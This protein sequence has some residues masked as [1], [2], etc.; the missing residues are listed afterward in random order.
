MATISG[1]TAGTTP[2]SGAEVL[3]A[4]VSLGGTTERFTTADVAR[5]AELF[6]AR[7]G[8]APER[9]DAAGTHFTTQGAGDGLTTWFPPTIATEAG[10]GPV[11]QSTGGLQ[12]FSRWPI[13]N[14]SGRI[15]EVVAEVEQVSVG[16][17][18]SPVAR[19][20]L[21]A[22][23]SDFSNDT[24]T[25]EVFGAAS[26]I[27]T[28]GQVLTIRQRF[29]AAAA[30]GVDVLAWADDANA[31]WFRPFVQVNLKSDLTGNVASSVAR[32]RRL[33]VQDITA[34]VNA[35]ARIKGRKRLNGSLI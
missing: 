28:A 26:A 11:A 12:L 30:A 32:V 17:S 1:Q 4:D 22:L 15:L 33:S 16:G 34:Q 24:G 18:E 31:A 5:L 29:G 8:D 6:A 13:S 19:V 7:N 20:G 10:Y 3:P 9:L 25:I 2:L 35:L 14:G 23:K 27:L 21:H